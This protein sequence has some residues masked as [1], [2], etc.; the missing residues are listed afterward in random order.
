MVKP[1][2]RQASSHGFVLSSVRRRRGRRHPLVGRC[3][4]DGTPH[5]QADGTQDAAEQERECASPMPSICSV[6]RIVVNKRRD[7]GAEQQSGDDAHLLEAAVEAALVLRCPFD[8]IGGGRSPFAAGRKALHQAGDDEQQRRRDADR[9]VGRQDADQHRADRHQRDGDE[10][11]G[12][13]S[14]RVADAAENDSAERAR[15]EA[16]PIGEERREQRGDFIALRKKLPRDVDR[17]VGVDRKIVPLEYVADHGR[18]D[19]AAR[20]R[21]TRIIHGSLPN[22]QKSAIPLRSCTTV[23]IWRV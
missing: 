11:R 6:V 22:P 14:V 5:P 21:L 1:K 15:D 23:L 2:A 3:L 8:D 7:T 17:D 19:G 16:E 18:A 10:Q 12:L 13:A 20:L 9:R 4:V